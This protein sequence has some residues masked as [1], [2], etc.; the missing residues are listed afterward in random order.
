MKK[1]LTITFI[2]LLIGLFRFSPIFGCTV[3]SASDAKTTLAGNNEDYN[4]NN[5]FMWFVPGTDGMVGGVYFGY[6]NFYEQ[7]GMNEQGLFFDGLATATNEITDS[8]DKPIH[9]GSLITKVMSECST[10]QEVLDLYDQYNLEQQGMEDYQLLFADSPGDSAVIEGDLAIRKENHYQV[11]TNFYQS[12]PGLGG[13]PCWRYDTACDMLENNTEITVDLFRSVLAAVHQEGRYPTLYSN[14]YDL[15]NKIVYLFYLHNFHEFIKI[16]LMEELKKGGRDYHIPS[17]FAEIILHSPDNGTVINASSVTFRW[18]GKPGIT[19]QLY[20]ST[21]P[22]FTDCQP[23]EVD[24]GRSY[25]F[26]FSGIGLGFLSLGIILF[27]ITFRG[28]KKSLLYL[29][30]PF[31]LVICLVSCQNGENS[32]NN[33]P[34]PSNRDFIVTVDNLQSGTTYYWKVTANASED[35]MSQSI[36]RVFTTGE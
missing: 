26:N 2:M 24:G 20:Y 33:E 13:Y 7:G 36:I 1:W 11:A 4:D 30:I 19:Y 27:S 3:F 14:I 32:E 28:R 12:N 22:D 9:R 5:T 10:V 6:G 35:F 16:D 21:D 18:E 23:I 31:L 34:E 25:A 15:K 8:L 17:L 29:A